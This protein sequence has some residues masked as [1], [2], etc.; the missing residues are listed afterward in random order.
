MSHCDDPNCPGCLALEFVRKVKLLGGDSVATLDLVALAI[1]EVYG[2]EAPP[3][4]EA[5]TARRGALH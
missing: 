5:A 1:A 2:Y 3:W 4:I